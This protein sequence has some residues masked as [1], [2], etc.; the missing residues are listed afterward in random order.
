M[1][2][3]AAAV[4]LPL[5]LGV[6]WPFFD[7]AGLALGRVDLSRAAVGLLV[8]AL[9]GSFVATATGQGEYDAAV[10]AG[11]SLERLDRHANGASTVP[12]VFMAL[13]G[14]RMWLPTRLGPAGAWGG[15]LLG[16]AGAALLL[17]VGHSGGE[18]VYTHGVGTPATVGGM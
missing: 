7:A 14:V 8:L 6:V 11:V 12:W 10:R 9:I 5:A 16:L 3:H 2:W 4:H 15:M 18:L 17:W 1:S 13:V